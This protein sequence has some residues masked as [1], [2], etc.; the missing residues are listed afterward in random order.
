MAASASCP[1]ATRF[2]AWLEG[3][4]AELREVYPASEGFI[5]VADRGSGEG[6][7]LVVDRG[8]FV[9]FVPPDQLGHAHPDRRWLATAELDTDYAIVLTTNSGLW[10]FIIGDTVRLVQ[11]NPP[12]P[13]HHRAHGV[14]PQRVWRA[15]D[16]GR[17]RPRHGRSGGGRRACTLATMR[18]AD[19]SRRTAHA[20][21]TCSSWKQR[22]RTWRARPIS[23]ACWTPPSRGRT[24][25]YADP[26][27]RRLRYGRSPGRAG[28]A[29]PL[30]RLDAQ[31]R[32][33]GRPKQGAPRHQRPGVAAR[34]AAFPLTASAPMPLAAMRRPGQAEAAAPACRRRHTR[35]AP[36][37][38]AAAPAPATRT[39]RRP[40]RAGTAA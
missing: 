25:T 28:A 2:A 40:E 17:A 5:A 9:E 13:G 18:A 3:G 31:P 32:Q 16:C 14:H 4:R 36:G 34:P 15:R 19:P 30:C 7:R 26:P 38:D 22:R 29:G 20:A 12:A 27:P 37:R 24:P 35:S 10:S 33:I 1:I 6:L 39:L 11:R 8:L 23:P 21:G